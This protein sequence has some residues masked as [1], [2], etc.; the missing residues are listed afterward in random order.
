VEP[1]QLREQDPSREQLTRVDVLGVRLNAGTMNAALDAVSQW[2]NDEAPGYA[3]FRDVHG[4]M[5]AQR[6]PEVLEAHARAALVACDGMP[7]VWASRW[8]GAQNAERVYGPEFMLALCARAETEGWKS[9]FYGG[10]P[11]VGEL[12]ST[13]LRERFP[14]LQC[15]GEYSPPFRPLTADEDAAAVKMINDSGADLVWVGLST[16]KQELWMADHLGR[17]DAPALL[18]VGAAFD[19]LTG[20]VRQAPRWIRRTGFEWLFRLAMEPRRLARR[21]LRNNPAFVRG[22]L[23]NPPRLLTDEPQRVPSPTEGNTSHG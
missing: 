15:V 16:P 13:R 22:I 14:R 21:Y 3:I 11:G 18:G 10:N 20:E 6:Q 2:V 12:L 23:S 9:F 19:F 1:Q 4:V 5:V 8:A 17:L 7:L